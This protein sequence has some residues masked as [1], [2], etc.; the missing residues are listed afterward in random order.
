MGGW[1]GGWGCARGWVGV[2]GGWKSVDY[3]YFVDIES[4]HIMQYTYIASTHTH[5]R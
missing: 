4:M 5:S 3:V 2:A 1:V